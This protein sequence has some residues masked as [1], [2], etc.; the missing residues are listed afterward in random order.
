MVC[1]NLGVALESGLNKFK[2]VVSSN[3]SKNNVLRMGWGL[4]EM[5]ERQLALKSP[6]TIGS[7]GPISLLI[8]NVRAPQAAQGLAVEAQMLFQLQ[9]QRLR[10]TRISSDV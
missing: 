6:D 4:K 10:H 2:V 1:I 8:Q 5:S 7:R 3:S 9:K